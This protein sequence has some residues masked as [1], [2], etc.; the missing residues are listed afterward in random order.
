MRSEL[1]SALIIITIAAAGMTTTFD[2]VDR[3]SV[4]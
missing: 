1:D 3:K 4:V 2:L